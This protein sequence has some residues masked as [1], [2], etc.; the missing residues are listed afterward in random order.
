MV[1]AGL[2][3]ISVLTDSSSAASNLIKVTVAYSTSL[4]VMMAQCAVPDS[5]G[6]DG[7]TFSQHL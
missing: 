3:N 1:V 5:L 2:Q 4:W 6:Q 7:L